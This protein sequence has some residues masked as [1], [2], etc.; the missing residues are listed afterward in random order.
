MQKIQELIIEEVAAQKSRLI[1]WAPV[2]FTIGIAL[3]FGLKSEPSFMLPSSVFV[4]TATSSFILWKF[5]FEGFY[6]K[7][8]LL[9]LMALSIIGAGFLV[10]QIKS[11]SVYTPMLLK[12]MNYA[13]IIG[14][15]E[16]IEPLDD[17]QGS[18][19]VLSNLKIEELTPKQTPRKVRIKIRQDDNLRAGQRIKILAGLNPASGPVAPNAFDF[20]RMAYFQGIGA[21]GFSYREPEIIE[22]VAQR[23]FGFK[24]LRQG[25]S[26]RI[27]AQTSEPQRSIITA[28]MTGQRGQ[29]VDEN[30]QALR[31]S[32]LA[33][34]LAI[35]GL[36]VGMV[37]GVVF[38][39]SRLL[40]ACSVR[41]ALH[42]PIKKYA[43]VFALLAALFYTVLV[44]ATIPT[45]RALL[46]T[47]LIMVAIMMDRSPF[48]LR[49]VAF[50]ALVVLIFSP[51]SLTSVSFQMSFSAVVALICFYE[52]LR[53]VWMSLH[54]QSG[55]VKKAVLYFV[56][57]S[58]TT[59]IAG[60]ATGLFALFHFQNFAVYGVL[61]NMVAVP[62]MAFIVMPLIVLSYLLMPFGI[63][64]L[65]MP[66]I[67]W[68]V[69][70]ILAT[71]HYVGGLDGAV[72]R[73]PV[74][75]HWIFIALVFCLWTMMVWKGRLKVFLLPVIFLLASLIT[76]YKQPDIQ[77]SSSSDLYGVRDQ[78][79]SIWVSTART[80]RYTAE[81]W[82]RLNGD[83]TKDRKTWPKEGS[84]DEFPL[85]C[86]SYGCRGEM[87][88][89]KVSI[90]FTKKAWQEDCDWADL[91]IA[92]RPIPYKACDAPYIIDFFDTWRNGAHAVWL[93]KGQIKIK[94][95]EGRRGKRLWTQTSAN[96]KDK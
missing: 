64:G 93:T 72:W 39:F 49:L 26:G 66:L 79:G 65:I 31:D 61:A 7:L 73:V 96:S 33:H 9:V 63:E 6:L 80:E 55:F 25:L 2:C 84:T 90:T 21:V 89:K 53:P 43:A 68:A 77:I 37:A 23:Q 17:N 27:E 22:D 16:S 24:A 36:H 3:Y 11:H 42:H 92:D 59:I 45:Q 78:N 81:N 14:D 32:G 4:L 29:I 34:L 41:L 60:F 52:W 46:M 58:L 5:K 83:Q 75:P 86:D 87:N 48:S 28:L 71:A 8:L 12:K 50:A 30:W 82:Y 51:Q 91:V 10:A 18:R 94:T 1:L 54:R 44:G 67:E 95:A 70:W 40:M 57:V 35:S 19:V 15:I 47:G 20:Q 74:W 62:L 56:G 85:T 38:F 13:D 76:I 69:G 88:N